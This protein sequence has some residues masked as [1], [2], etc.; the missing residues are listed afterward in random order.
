MKKTKPIRVMN[1]GPKGGQF[2]LVRDK[3]GHLV[4]KYCRTKPPHKSVTPVVTPTLVSID[5]T[6]KIESGTNK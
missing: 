4:K 2:C 5:D 3:T 6:F 1:T